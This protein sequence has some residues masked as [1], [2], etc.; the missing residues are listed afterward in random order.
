MQLEIRLNAQTSD[1]I[2][3]VH[4]TED[5]EFHSEEGHEMF[6]SIYIQTDTGAEHVGDFKTREY[7]EHIASL[8]TR[9]SG[10]A[11]FIGDDLECLLETQT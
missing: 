3:C 9:I 10:H 4:S 7:A 2:L 8:L 11:V 1:D 6:W 5:Y